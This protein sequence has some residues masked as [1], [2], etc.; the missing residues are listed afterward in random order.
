MNRT[1]SRAGSYPAIQAIALEQHAI[2]ID[3]IRDGRFAARVL[4]PRAGKGTRDPFDAATTTDQI[5]AQHRPT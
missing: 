1:F 5:I 4:P 3:F 2:G